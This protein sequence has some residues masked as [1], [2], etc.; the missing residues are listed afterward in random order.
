[1][2]S[3]DRPTAMTIAVGIDPGVGHGDAVS[4]GRRLEGFPVHRP[5]R[6]SFPVPDELFFA[7]TSINS[8]T[9]ATFQL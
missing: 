8:S 9:A 3:D 1:M 2:P 7:R 6:G 5:G 4:Q